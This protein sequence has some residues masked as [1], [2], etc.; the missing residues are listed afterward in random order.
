MWNNIQNKCLAFTQSTFE[1]LKILFLKNIHKFFS[2][3]KRKTILPCK[4]H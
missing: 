3:E 1:K 2:K 4:K